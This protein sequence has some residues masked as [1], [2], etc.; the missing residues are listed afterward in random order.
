MKK[1]LTALFLASVIVAGSAPVMGAEVSFN[2][3]GLI[4]ANAGTVV[5]S[6]GYNMLG[7]REVFE[8]LGAS[9]QWNSVKRCVTAEKDGTTVQLFVDTNKALV[10][11]EYA[12]LPTSCVNLDGHIYVP[13]RF[14]SDAFG[15]EIDWNQ[16][17]HR[18]SINT[19]NEKYTLLNVSAEVT[20]NTRVL[21][22]D[23][24]LKMALNRSSSLKDVEDSVDYLDEMREDLG[25]LM[26]SLDR[27]GSMYNANL[28][29]LSQQTDDILAAQLAVQQNI[30]NVIQAARNIKNV[31]IQK[32]MVSVN[33][34]MVTDGVELALKSYINNIKS[35]RTQIQLLS[36]K[37][38]LG[39][40]NISNLELKNKLG[41]ESDYSLQSAKTTQLSDESSLKMLYLNL[42]NQKQALKTL[43]GIDASED[44][45]VESDVAFNALENVE[46]EKY[47]DR[48]RETDLSV[49]SLKNAVTLAEYKERTNKAYDS[50]SEISVRNELNSAKRKL[51]D[52]Q[53]NLEKNIRATYNNIKQLEETNTNL[54]RSVEQAKADYNSAVTS[55][56]AGMATEYQVKAAKLGILSAEKAVEDNARTY[57]LMTFAFEKPYLLDSVQK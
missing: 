6:N 35:T 40:E 37:V 22:Y 5:N 13:V 50:E 8:L 16:E 4:Q 33:E 53:D 54:L 43:L 3:D 32:S 57:D 55:Y 27:Q 9:V 48:M 18:I 7:M 49:K 30:E 36:E 38:E 21:T 44:I 28:F 52:S 11:G 25:D 19:G 39:K 34:E 15:Y 17:A 41:Y 20:D 24:A 23:E 10:N 45:Y 12:K 31:E 56:R 1:K 2:V 29:N 26:W 51:V 47:V 42:D 46:L 14:V